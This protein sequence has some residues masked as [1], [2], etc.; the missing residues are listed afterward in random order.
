MSTPFCAVHEAFF[1]KIER[2]GSFFNYFN[3]TD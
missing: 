1:S 3:L 2:D